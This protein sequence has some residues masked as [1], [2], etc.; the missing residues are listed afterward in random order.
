[1]KR[2]RPD[3]LLDRYRTIRDATTTE[4]FFR[5]PAHKK[6][7]EMWCAAH[8]ARGYEKHYGECFVWISDSDEQTDA[9]FEL[10]VRRV[11]HPFQITELMQPGRR[12]GDEYRGGESGKTFL[13][14]WGPGT[15]NGPM[16]VREAIER[17]AK[18]RYAAARKLDL[19]VYV[20]FPAYE[21]RFDRISKECEEAAK[22]F[23]S[24]WLLNGNAIC[25][26]RCGDGFE[27]TDGWLPIDESLANADL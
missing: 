18:K 16:W 26:I 3:E 20:N 4:A 25:C 5:D 14:D 1:M 12:R 15:A 8:F 27:L 13:E 22:Q 19:L 6:T 23:A 2:Y 24:V 21:Q 7:Q 9:D 17:K 10:E 11:C